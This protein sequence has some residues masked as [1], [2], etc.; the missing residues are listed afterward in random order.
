MENSG[1]KK[2]AYQQKLPKV[3]IQE[4]KNIRKFKGEILAVN[5]SWKEW[6]PNS[7]FK[8]SK[9]PA[10]LCVSGEGLQ[11]CCKIRQQKAWSVRVESP[12]WHSR[13]KLKSNLTSKETTERKNSSLPKYF[14]ADP[15]YFTGTK[16]TRTKVGQSRQ[17]AV[18]SQKTEHR[19]LSVCFWPQ[20]N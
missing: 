5:K 1:R 20:C 12:N 14:L 11:G 13:W 17:A 16:E 8:L 18:G 7:E 3:R 10:M 19:L 9:R 15:Q 4:W 6:G 2:Q